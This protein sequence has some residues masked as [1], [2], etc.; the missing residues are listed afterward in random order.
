MHQAATR[1]VGT[2]LAVLAFAW[3]VYPRDARAATPTTSPSR[4]TLKVYLL[5]G[6]SNMEGHG[7]T[8]QEGADWLHKIGYPDA[9]AMEYLVE[10]PEYLKTLDAEKYSFLKAF[11][12]RWIEPRDDVWAVHVDSA[13]G[14]PFPVQHTKAEK[15]DQWRPGEK[16][17][18]PG[19]GSA[20]NNV[21]K[22]GPEIGIGQCLGEALAAP[23]YLYK[24]DHGGTDLATAW[25]PPSA[26]KQRGGAVGPNYTHTVETFQAFLARLDA[27]LKRDGKLTAYHDAAGYEVCGFVWLQG[28]ND[29]I[30]PERRAEYEANLTDLARDLRTDLALPAL[31]VVMIEGSD[32]NE[33]MN[34]ARKSAVA[35]LNKDHPD[36]AVFVPT[37][38]LNA[39][40]KGGFH[41]EVRAEN[42]L[43]VGCARGK[44]S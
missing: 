36:S 43:E 2:L 11:G 8:H 3:P 32:M 5:A 1:F 39:G 12:P 13:T 35:A 42:Y 7:Y 29:A 10:H 25:R 33:E 15:K 44:R 31:P 6:Q 30:K 21:S 28:W 9:T 37:S 18:Q 40:K 14:K 38:G 4:T 34:A 20:S 41:F 16:P 22:F 26:A 24:S 17:L 19:F 23:V 27:D